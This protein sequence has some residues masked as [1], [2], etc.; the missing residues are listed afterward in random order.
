MSI[1]ACSKDNPALSEEQ[2]KVPSD[3]TLSSAN[4][5]IGHGGETL[6]LT[7]TAPERPKATTDASWI[8]IGDGIFKNYRLEFTLT[9]E[10]NGAFERRE[11]T[12]TVSSGRVSKSVTVSQ[13]GREKPEI[14]DLD[15]ARNLVTPNPTAE[16]KALYDYLLGI[17]GS[18]TV[19][20]VMADVNWNTSI[21]QKVYQQTGKYPAMNC[22]DFIHIYV[23]SGN[24]WI[25]YQD[26]NPVTSW[27]DAGGI[28]SLMWHFNVPLTETTTPGSNGSGVTC[29]PDQ[30]TFKASNALKE[31]TWENAWYVQQ[32]NKVADIILQLQGK[33]I[34]AIWRPYHEAAGNYHALKWNGSAWFW[35]GAEGPDVFKALWNDMYDRFAAKGIRN[36]IWVWTAQNYN[37]DSSSYDSD[38]PWYPGDGRVDVVAR[39]IYGS[40]ASGVALDFVTLQ[41]TYNHKMVTLG[42]CGH[43]NDAFPALAAIWA[44]GGS[45]SWFMPWYE[46]GGTMVS[47][48]WWKAAFACE[49][50][51]TREDISL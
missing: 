7:V 2:P 6:T 15:I 8:K 18:K 19:S 30:T 9:V 48:D 45:Y 25:N 3:I 44:E 26:L 11:A 10:A 50:V 46:N 13:R 47:W 49:Y 37:G 43:G 16:A 33:G 40:T 21:A 29:S 35:W 1:W 31:G 23:P 41:N 27:H 42:E 39:D 24:G 5:E 36:L 17:Y 51:L 12:V 4:F 20:S 28:V 34:A 14:N 32:M 38:A 22:Y